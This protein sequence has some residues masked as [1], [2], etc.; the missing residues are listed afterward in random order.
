MAWPWKTLSRLQ[1][2]IPRAVRGFAPS[3]ANPPITA[4]SVPLDAR[5]PGVSFP[6]SHIRP[7]SSPFMLCYNSTSGCSIIHPPKTAKELAKE[8]IRDAAH[9]SGG[10]AGKARRGALMVV[11]LSGGRWALAKVTW[12]PTR[13]D[14]LLPDIYENEPAAEAAARRGGLPEV[15]PLEPAPKVRS[16]CKGCFGSLIHATGKIK[17]G[18]ACKYADEGIDDA[19]RKDQEEAK[20]Y[21]SGSNA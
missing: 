15:Q 5:G 11:E 19:P 3:A 6:S 14:T 1:D 16:W 8:V 10:I 12:D 17:H 21:W 18:P 7:L 4:R 13:V 9:L 2:R 20:D